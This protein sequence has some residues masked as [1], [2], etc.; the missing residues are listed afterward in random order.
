MITFGNRGVFLDYERLI[1]EAFDS[2]LIVKEAKLIGHKGRIKGNRIAIKKDIPTLK[3]KAC[4]LAE[5][6]GH[7]H[8]SH[9]NILDQDIISNRKQEYKARLWSY[10]KQ[11]GLNG[12]IDSY[13]H[14]CRTIYEI[15][16]FLDVTEEFFLEAIECYKNKYGLFATIDN[17]VIYFIPS[18][19]IMKLL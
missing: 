15:I 19:I 16:E 18:L 17:Y 2:N 14:G 3:E 1:Q 11:I 6:L 9:G 13:N 7:F 12:L 4:I 8:T 5:E 10:N